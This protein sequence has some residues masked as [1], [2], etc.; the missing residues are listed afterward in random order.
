MLCQKFQFKGAQEQGHMTLKL[1]LW[2]WLFFLITKATL[3]IFFLNLEENFYDF[4][5]IPKCR[6]G[7]NR[8]AELLKYAKSLKGVTRF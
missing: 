1:F 2:C 6:G 7:S 4:S 5:P 3:L 8:R